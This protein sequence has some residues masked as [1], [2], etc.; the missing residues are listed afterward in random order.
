METNIYGLVQSRPYFK[1]VCLKIGIVLQV[2]ILSLQNR[3][4]KEKCVKRFVTYVGRVQHVK[5]GLVVRACYV[6]F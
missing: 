6:D 2:I 4:S 5:Q 1:S 3:V